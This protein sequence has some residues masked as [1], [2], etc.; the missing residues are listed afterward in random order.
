MGNL[1]VEH[2]GELLDDMSPRPLLLDFFVNVSEYGVAIED[3]LGAE[4]AQ[5]H[6]VY[7]VTYLL[8]GGLHDLDVEDQLD[9][10]VD[11]T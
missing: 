8:H 11:S 6:L 3:V 2:V 9:Q 10:L 1:G 5:R 7:I 4:L